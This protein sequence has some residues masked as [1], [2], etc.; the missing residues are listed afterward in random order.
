MKDEKEGVHWEI[1]VAGKGLIA[2]G[3]PQKGKCRAKLVLGS[4]SLTS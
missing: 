1:R 4:I 3:H 2:T